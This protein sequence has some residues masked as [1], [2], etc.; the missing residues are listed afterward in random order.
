MNKRVTKLVKWLAALFVAV[1]VVAQ[2]YS[3]LINPVTTDTVYAHSSF[4]G[5]SALGYII[6]NETVITKDVQ[7]ALGY[8][9]ENGG[10][11]SK[12]G[13]IANIY[14]SSEDAE[15]KVQLEQLEQRIA[16]LENIQSY[17]DLNAADVNALKSNIHNS[18]ILAMQGTQKGYVDSELA[19]TEQLL[20][21]IN[22][23]QI[24]TGQVS[25]FNALI[26][27]LKSERDALKASMMPVLDSIRSPESGYVIYSVDGYENAVTTDEISTLTAED[28]QNISPSDTSGGQV[29]KIVSDYEWYIAAEMPF[30][31]VLNLQEGATVT[32]KTVLPSSP[33]IK[34]TVKHINKQSVQDNAVVVFSCNTMNTELAATRWLE[35]TVVYEQYDGLKVDNRAIRVVDG[36]K[37][38][39][40]LTASQVKFVA[41]NVIWTGENYSIVEREATDKKVLRIYDEIIVKGKS[42]YDGKVIN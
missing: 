26:A 31:E 30:S 1:F 23:Y 19:A 21:D 13:T 28:M 39:Y 24:I 33:E 9:V 27:T 12:K 4:S 38:V 41:V 18:I 35:M 40:V 37:G 8:E 14:Q 22:R 29:C 17:N 42:L 34:V 10:R 6:R 7:G 25:D 20:A 36:V 32:L 15:K 16:S 2:L 3:V 11:V 5:Y